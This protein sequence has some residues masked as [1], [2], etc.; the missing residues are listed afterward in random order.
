MS[1]SSFTL[2]SL[3][4]LTTH[5]SALFSSAPENDDDHHHHLV[6]R[7]YAAEVCS[8]NTT[9]DASSSTIP[10]C[11]EVVNIEAA[12][13]PNST[14]PTEWL[15]HA[16]C[17]CEGSYFQDWQGCQDCLYFH[18]LRTERDEAFYESVM[19]IA[20]H[21]LCDFYAGVS[22]AAQPTAP[23]ASLYSSAA[24]TVAQPTTGA[25]ISSDQAPSETAVSLYFTPSGNQGP[26]VTFTSAS[27]SIGNGTITST[28]KTS[29]F[30]N[31]VKKTATTS[32]SGSAGTASIEDNGAYSTKAPGSLLL[33]L[34]GVAI[35]VGL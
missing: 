8:P 19:G 2:L 6:P 3:V 24:A 28:S 1:S 12:C 17:M 11:I 20:S 23:F 26:G 14:S 30:S 4:A 22:G 16:E 15:D 29:S 27:T 34:A 33:G 31:S 9:T 5:A 13:T 35:A 18:G 21:S 10:P 32:A 25:T 7:D